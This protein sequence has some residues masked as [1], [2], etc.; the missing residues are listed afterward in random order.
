MQLYINI[1]SFNF[2][3]SPTVLYTTLSCSFLCFSG[4]FIFISFLSFMTL[5]C[6]ALMHF[7]TL[8]LHVTSF[9]PLTSSQWDPVYLFYYPLNLYL[10]RP[11]FLNLQPETYRAHDVLCAQ[12]II[13]TERHQN[14]LLTEHMY[15]TGYYT[16][17]L[18]IHETCIY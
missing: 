7:C 18:F 5:T 15:Y 6:P 12:C 11:P 2:Y 8:P 13:F 10:V 1:S 9:S 17:H 3:L 16:K 14:N 4:C